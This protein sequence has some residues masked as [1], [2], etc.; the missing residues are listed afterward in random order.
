MSYVDRILTNIENGIAA[1]TLGAAAI[2]AIVSV[3]LRYVFDSSLIWSQE[4]VIFLII[5]SSFIGAV[6]ALRHNEHVGVNVLSL[7]AGTRGKWVLASLGSLITV[8][9]CVILGGL[10]WFMVTQPGA[11]S[12]TTPT[13]NL[14]LWLVELAVP[15]GLTLMFLR[16]LETLYRTVRGTPAF[17]DSA[18]EDNRE[19]VDK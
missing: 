11:R 12:I 17:P 10:A 1:I 6:I 3:I 5:F 16:A 8:I 13:L 4:A 19:E 15:I 9:Y 14:P 7:V 2:I 18:R